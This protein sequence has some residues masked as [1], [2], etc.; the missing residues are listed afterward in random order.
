[1]RL[2]YTLELSGALPL[3]FFAYRTVVSA[4]MTVLTTAA[5]T[6]ALWGML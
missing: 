1:M 3:D 4:T 5:G 6:G 2:D